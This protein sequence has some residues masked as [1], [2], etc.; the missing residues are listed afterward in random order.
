MRQRIQSANINGGNMRKRIK[1]V[2]SEEFED[3]RRLAM[4][5]QASNEV[6]PANEFNRSDRGLGYQYHIKSQAITEISQRPLQPA[7]NLSQI[8]KGKINPSQTQ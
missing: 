1:E 6:I 4:E 2:P 8:L 7:A 3:L 5:R